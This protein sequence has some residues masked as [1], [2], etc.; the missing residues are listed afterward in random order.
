[1]GRLW[2]LGNISLKANYWHV[3]EAGLGIRSF[4]HRSFAH[5]LRLLRSN[6]RLWVIC[7]DRS[8]QM[9]YCDQKAQVTHDKWAT[10]SDLLRLLMINEQMSKW[11]DERMSESLIR[12]FSHKKRAI[13]SKKFDWNRILV[14]FC[15]FF[16]KLAIYSFPF[17][18]SDVRN[19]LRSLTKNE[20][21]SKSLVFWINCS[22][23]H[24]LAKNKRFV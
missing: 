19:L 12:S 15:M 7:S 21:I 3:C 24:F 6:E 18:M 4:A 2:R 16:K 20:Q 11:A 8:G 13:H 9:S 10:I 17:L 22:F 23:A 5:S 14:H 1:M